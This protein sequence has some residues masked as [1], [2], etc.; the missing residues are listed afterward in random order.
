[1]HA[2]YIDRNPRMACLLTYILTYRSTQW[3]KW[4]GYQN[5]KKSEDNEEDYRREKRTRERRKNF[6]A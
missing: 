6:V 1:M 4:N 3:R 2:Y 5:K